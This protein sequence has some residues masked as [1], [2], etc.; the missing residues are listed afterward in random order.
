MQYSLL[1]LQKPTSG[2]S[3]GL[4]VGELLIFG[5]APKMTTLDL[6]IVSRFR[7]HDIQE[8]KLASV[9]LGGIR[10]REREKLHYILLVVTLYST[11][12]TE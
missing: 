12:V 5:K 10:E 1:W 11:Y 4:Q 6:H 8:V 2:S 9:Q 7:D 3:D